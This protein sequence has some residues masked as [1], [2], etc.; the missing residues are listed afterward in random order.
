MRGQETDP[1]QGQSEVWSWSPL[2]FQFQSVGPPDSGF[3]FSVNVAEDGHARAEDT[4]P[5]HG[6]ARNVPSDRA[7]G[8]TNK[9]VLRVPHSWSLHRVTRGALPGTRVASLVTLPLCCPHKKRK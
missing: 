7:L 5:K 9:P 6:T 8:F 2:V 3:S 4:V 1:S